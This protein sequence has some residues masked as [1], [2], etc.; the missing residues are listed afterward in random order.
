MTVGGRVEEEV[1]VKARKK[2]L[3][4]SARTRFTSAREMRSSAMRWDSCVHPASMRYVRGREGW[5]EERRERR[6]EEK[7]CI[8]S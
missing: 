8:R 1:E 4:V 6:K 7:R 5:S 2:G 3:M